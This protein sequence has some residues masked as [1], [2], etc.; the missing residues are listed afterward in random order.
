VGAAESLYP[1]PKREDVV[2]AQVLHVARLESRGLGHVDQGAEWHELAVRKDVALDECVALPEPARDPAT[3]AGSRLGPATHQPVVEEEPSRPERTMH[4]G[5][6]VGQP[7]RA[8]VLAHPHAH[9]LVEP[10]VDGKVAVVA[11]LD[12]HTVAD[13]CRGESLARQRRLRLA[14][15]DPDARHTEATR[16]ILEQSAPSAADVEHMLAGAETQLPADVL[17]LRLL[18]R[19]EILRAGGE[20]RARVD[21]SPVEPERVEVVADVVVVAHRDRVAL[22]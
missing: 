8:D 2:L 11:H 20:V 7:R 14:Q 4:G 16:R 5:E 6:V 3:N 22:A 17:Q 10:P 1:V 12:A 21:H 9:R 15:R 18:R 19:V 13:A